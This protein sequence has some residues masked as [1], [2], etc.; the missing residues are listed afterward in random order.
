VI[1]Q[2]TAEKAFKGPIVTEVSAATTF[3]PA[4]DYH[5]KFT[6]RTGQGM[7]HIPYASV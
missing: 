7:C 5:Q 3:W 6:E 2:L 4:E 1:S